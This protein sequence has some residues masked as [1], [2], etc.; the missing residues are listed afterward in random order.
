[1]RSAWS[2][3]SRVVRPGMA[4]DSWNPLLRRRPDHRIAGVA[5]GAHHQV[6]RK[7]LQNGPG[8]GRGQGQVLQGDQ[9]VPDLPGLQRAVEAGDLHRPEGPASL[10]D[11]LPLDPPPGPYKED[12]A[13]RLPRPDQARQ[14][15]RRIHMP[16]GPP[17]GEDHTHPARTSLLNQTVSILFLKEKYQKNFFRETLFRLSFYLISMSPLTSTRETGISF[18]GPEAEVSAIALL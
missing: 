7:V 17:A 13:V 15:Q 3:S 1:M 18:T 6:R 12:L 11:E 14:R 16:R 10:L 9:V 8:L 5:P 4:L 2:S